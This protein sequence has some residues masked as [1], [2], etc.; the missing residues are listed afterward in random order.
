VGT[1][2]G[3]L[4]IRQI[5]V[6]RAE[7]TKKPAPTTGGFRVTRKRNY[8]GAKKTLKKVKNVER[9]VQE[10]GVKWTRP[11]N[12]LTSKGDRQKGGGGVGV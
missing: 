1:S 2:F 7:V 9:K 8:R 6:G 12:V 3:V 11:A 5:L 10:V 4:I